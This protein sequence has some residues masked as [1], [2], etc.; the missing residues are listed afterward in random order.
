[1]LVMWASYLIFFSTVSGSQQPLACPWTRFRFL[2]NSYP[3]RLTVS[4]PLLIIIFCTCYS[5]PSTYSFFSKK[6]IQLAICCVF[7][8][9]VEWKQVL[10]GGACSTENNIM[11]KCKSSC[12]AMFQIGNFVFS[13]IVSN[14]LTWKNYLVS[15]SLQKLLFLCK[16]CCTLFFPQNADI[17]SRLLHK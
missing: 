8:S 10:L 1:M 6:N 13:F 12:W 9:L 3:N 4:L 14:V 7:S 15:V 5:C 11:N 16:T 17:S 2:V